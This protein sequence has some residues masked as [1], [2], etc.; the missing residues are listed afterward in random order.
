M[1]GLGF[2]DIEIFNLDF[3]ARQGWRMLQDLESLNARVLKAVYFLEGEMLG[4]TVGSSPSQV[5]RETLQ[6]LKRCLICRAG[7]GETIDPWNDNWIPRDGGL[8]PMACLARE[9]PLTVS[10]FIGTPPGMKKSSVNT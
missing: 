4:E 7:T 8:H 9:P 10:A 3:L 2:K 5:W 6:V 1:G